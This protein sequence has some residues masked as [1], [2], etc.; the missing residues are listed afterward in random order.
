MAFAPRFVNPGQILLYRNGLLARDYGDTR[1]TTDD[2]GTGFLAAMSA[3]Q[4][5]D[6]I[7]C[8][9]GTFTLVNATLSAS[10]VNIFCNGTTLQRKSSTNYTHL[11]KSTGSG[12]KISGMTVDGGGA[13]NTGT[14]Y[15][16]HV[17][18]DKTTVSQVTVKGTRGTT[19]SNGDGSG[20][21][22][23]NA[24]DVTVSDLTSDDTGYSAIWLLTS[25]RAVVDG[26][27]LH[28]AV[29]KAI[30]INSASD[31]DLITLSNIKALADD[32]SSQDNH[33]SL[34]TNIDDGVWLGEL[35]LNNVVLCDADMVSSGVSYN[36]A[37]GYQMMKLQNIRK[38]V[39]DGC[40]MLHGTNTG[41]GTTRSLYIQAFASNV[42]PDELIVKN[43]L[44]SGG[45]VTGLPLPYMHF[46]NNHVGYRSNESGVLWYTFEA[47]E[48][49]F[50]GN[51]FD[52]HA[53]TRV[54]TLSSST[55]ATDRI[56]FTK[57]RFKS[58]SSSATYIFQQSGNKDLTA[59][60]GVFEF[61]QSNTLTNSGS[62]TMYR[63]NNV[64]G[65]LVLTT[66]NNGDMLLDDGN[67]GTGSGQHPDPGAIAPYFT[68]LTA[69]ENG[70]KIINKNWSPDG[71]QIVP[72]KAFVAHGGAWKEWT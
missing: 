3:A 7:V 43:S 19:I 62:G 37:N 4:S 66:D 14:G 12:C 32:N 72:E 38:V 41:T 35:R 2:Y 10:G 67:I 65:N 25:N 55:A 59:C 60:A 30:S 28:N 23:D 6:S 15:G 48:A 1:I 56:R 44:F 34:N 31:I 22:I 11:F 52:M 53:G 57:N 70:R 36:S 61:D 27:V 42:A 51:T 5:G 18:G 29:N 26:A 9:P 71:T 16:V 40:Q 47:R 49:S 50:I 46:E 68:S 13:A 24:D 64:N 69:A 8:G 20:L 17:T 33:M 58:N 21:K 54:F 39:I 45:L 63:S